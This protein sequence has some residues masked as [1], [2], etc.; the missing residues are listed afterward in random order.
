MA[1]TESSRARRRWLAPGTGPFSTARGMLPL[2]AVCAFLFA[3]PIVMLVVG[4]FRNTDPSLPAEWGLRGFT[5]YTDPATHQAL[6][7]SI[8]LAGSTTLI[9][10]AAALVA[11]FLVT[12]TRTL[13][14]GLVTP[15]MALVV[16]LPPLFYAIS[17]GMFGNAR[18]GLLNTTFRD[19]TGSGATL[20][21]VN[22]W[23]GLI[24]VISLK[25]TAFSYL[26]LL[27]PFMALDR[28]FEEASQIAGAGRLRT[29]LRI[30][31]PVLAPAVTGVLILNFV[32]GLEFFDVPLFLGTPAGI[33]VFST[34]IYGLI[35]D[36]TPAEYGGASALSLLLIVVVVVLVAAQWRVLGKRQFTT[37]SGKGYRS[38][39]WDIGAWRWAGTA[40]IAAFVLLAL[41]LPLA[42]LVIGSLQ[43]FFGAP[44]FGDTSGGF[45]LVHYAS[46]LSDDE[47]LAALRTTLIV[48]VVGGVLAMA[49]AL[50]ISY[51]ATHSTSRLRRIVELLT[52]LPWA[53]PG[54]VL[55]LAIVWAYVS[56][57]GL[58]QLYA[59][60]WIVMLGLVVAAMPIASRS[61][62]AA[63][64]QLGRELEEASRVSGARPIRMFLDVVLPLILPSFLSGWFLVA[65]V[66]SGNLAVPILLTSQDNVTVPIVVFELYTQGETAQA[67]ALFVIVLTALAAGL[68]VLTLAGR[69]LVR[70][71]SRRRAAT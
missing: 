69:L 23:A 65:I 20:F 10:T 70:G 9:A 54:V 19:L 59:T 4:A 28:S 21:D 47:T 2:L 57:P 31:L 68:T 67:A 17:W 71:Q 13:G 30:D 46:L 29:L 52:W 14:R 6:L 22:S 37:V 3:Y 58:R 35:K 61:A 53:V 48:S 36:Q 7:N 49:L 40:F 25:A 66:I 56:T 11:A 43:P 24:L 55:S 18:I 38:D 32:I 63:I 45:S 16:A 41:V 62:Q 60:I 50:L 34:Q 26:L 42:Q 51:A 12:R 15:A 1:V 8:V 27:G 33:T 39:P 5:A 44:I 64:G